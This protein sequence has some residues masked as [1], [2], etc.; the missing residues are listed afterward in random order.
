V[1]GKGLAGR[2]W[3]AVAARPALLCAVVAVAV[4]FARRP[5]ARRGAAV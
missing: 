2:Y 4:L 5:D 3:V 1:R